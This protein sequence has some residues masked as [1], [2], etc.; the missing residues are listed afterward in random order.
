MRTVKEVAEQLGFPE[1]T[2]RYYTDQGLV[3][4]LKRDQN[5]I[6]LFDEGAVSWL[7]CAKHLRQCGMS[8]DD[9]RTYINLCRQGEATIG[10]RYE[11]M[12]KQRETALAQLEEAR[13]RAK[14]IAE[15]TE[16]YSDFLTGR[17]AE[18]KG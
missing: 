11:I 12:K 3:P 17:K 10:K 9:I 7:L 14:Y 15:K 5:N 16:Q 6:R 18:L 8:I 1:H 4:D 13:Q 2:I